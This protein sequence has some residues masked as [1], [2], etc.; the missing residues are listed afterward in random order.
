MLALEI[1]V[2]S[3]N[4]GKKSKATRRQEEGEKQEEAR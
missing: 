1:N 4:I 2:M 3:C